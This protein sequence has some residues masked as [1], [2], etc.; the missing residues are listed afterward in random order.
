LSDYDRFTVIMNKI[1]G[2]VPLKLRASNIFGGDLNYSYAG[3]CSS[4]YYE[5]A[6]KSR[7]HFDVS[8]TFRCC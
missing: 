3:K 1:T 2:W 8:Y 4:L 6:V 5:E 7:A